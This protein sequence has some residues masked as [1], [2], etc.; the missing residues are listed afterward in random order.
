LVKPDFRN[1]VPFQPPGVLVVV[2]EKS[3]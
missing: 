2:I 3:G 1:N